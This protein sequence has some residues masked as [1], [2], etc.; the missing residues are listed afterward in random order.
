MVDFEVF[1]EELLRARGTSR[2]K[3]S[4]DWIDTKFQRELANLS[5]CQRRTTRPQLEGATSVTQT[6]RGWH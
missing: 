4:L 1:L 5:S 2:K 3:L 6:P